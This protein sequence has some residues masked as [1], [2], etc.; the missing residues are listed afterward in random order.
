MK[1]HPKAEK[2]QVLNELLRNRIYNMKFRQA[3]QYLEGQPEDIQKVVHALSMLFGNSG[4][5]D[6]DGAMADLLQFT[7]DALMEKLK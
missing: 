1:V 4:W 3:I 7:C 5:E 6:F 2:E